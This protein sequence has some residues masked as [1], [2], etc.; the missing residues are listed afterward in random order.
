M[1]LKE[2][3]LLAQPRILI[4]E[5]DMLEQKI[6]STNISSFGYV[7]ES[8]SSGSEAIEKA[9]AHNPDVIIIDLFLPDINGIKVCRLLRDGKETRHIPIIAV[10]S[11]DDRRLRID[12]LNA[13]AND[14][15]RKPVDFSELLIKIRNLV[16]MKSYEDM[17]VKHDVLARTVKTI[18]TAKRQ[19]EQSMDCIRDAVLLADADGLIVRCNK[20]LTTLTGKT[21]QGLLK[22]KWQDVLTE[23]G[24]TCITGT[25]EC[26]EYQHSTGKYFECSAYDIANNDESFAAV[27]IVTLHDITDRKRAEE[28]LQ[29]SRM[30]LQ[31]ALDEISALIQEVAVRKNF[32]VRFKNPNLKKCYEFMKCDKKNCICYEDG[33][34]EQ[35]CWQRAGTFCK[36]A[37]QGQFAMKYATCTKCPFFEDAAQDPYAYLGEQFNNMM[38]ILENQHAD[39][40]EA[41]NELKMVQSQ[42]LQQEKMASIGQ[43]AAGVAHEINNPMGFIISNLNSLKKYVEK[44]SAY[45]AD[46]TAAVGRCSEKCGNRDILA[47]IAAKRKALKI[48]YIAGDID[49]LIKESLEGADRVKKIVQDLK[50]FSRIDESECKTADI[51][52]GLE[53]TINIVWNELKYKATLVKDYGDIPRTVCNPGQLNQV[54]MNLLVN[55]A[56]AIE[57]HGEIRVKT[58]QDNGRIN[59]TISDTGCGMPADVQN[60]IFEPFFTTKEVG[61]GTGLGLSIAYDII[62]KH[63]GEIRLESAV[64]KGSNFIIS[65]PVVGG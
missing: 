62:K 47:E 2:N 11:S 17:K 26:I 19:W 55:A 24:F 4:A 3:D 15:I 10:T 54:F 45:M 12:S 5:D 35:R 52:A 1:I 53:S 7:C 27:S 61:K 23:G 18:E 58:W 9:R 43:L 59:I 21:Y 64:G 38:Y 40:A 25:I 32:G 33:D 50:S 51:N 22:R 36:G 49:N 31:K 14:F 20:V 39:L 56:H 16:Q 6:M 34:R 60:R 46:Q 42:V 13:G 63:H 41:Y 65:I 48:D 29:N 44:I 28:E 37:V 57:Q 8:A 30:Q